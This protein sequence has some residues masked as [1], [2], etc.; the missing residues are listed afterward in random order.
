MSSE[1]ILYALA[2]NRF[3]S[4]VNH[5][6]H[7]EIVFVPPVNDPDVFDVNIIDKH[8]DNLI[9]K[10]VLMLERWDAEAAAAKEAN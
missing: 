10:W 4:L 5:G 6:S 8:F 2:D 3:K 9:A 1:Q 7:W